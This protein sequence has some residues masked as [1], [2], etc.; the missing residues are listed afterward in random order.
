MCKINVTIADWP[1]FA[2]YFIKFP[3]GTVPAGKVI[4]S[5]TLT[6]HHFGNPGVGWGDP[7]EPSYLQILTVGQDWDQNTLTWNTAPMAREN[8]SAAWVDP[9]FA[10]G[11]DPGVPRTWD[12]SRAVAEAY[13]A[14]EPLDLAIYSADWPLSQW[15]LFLVV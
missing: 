9:L 4:I 1:C 5:A 2:K 14:G 13:N 3:L 11:G 12:V 10:Y 15:S 7:L 6:L 8:V